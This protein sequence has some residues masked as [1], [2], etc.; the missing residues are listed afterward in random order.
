MNFRRTSESCC[1]KIQCLLRYLVGVL[2]YPLGFNAYLQVLRV[3]CC[4]AVIS[5]TFCESETDWKHKRI[6][7][8]V[9]QLTKRGRMGNVGR[10][11]IDARYKLRP[12][13][14]VSHI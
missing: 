13:L 4:S 7:L 10:I 2:D 9:I 6:T 11:K 5:C 1:S 14:L 3:R 8:L 12:R